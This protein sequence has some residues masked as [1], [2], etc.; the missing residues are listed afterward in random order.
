M[1]LTGFYNLI[2][3]KGNYNPPMLSRE[4]FKGKT[5]ALDGDYLIY[6]AMFGSTKGCDIQVVT[7][8]NKIIEWLT[9]AKSS[10]IQTI[11]VTTGGL[12]PEEKSH[13]LKKRKSIR[14]MQK[15]KSEELSLTFQR[16]S[17]KIDL[18]LKKKKK[19]EA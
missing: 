13:V 2:C 14:E 12:P 16:T 15:R 7:I 11:F 9:T 4:D 18:L 3:N 1:G 6:K 5:I 10:G 17:E 19:T 8:A